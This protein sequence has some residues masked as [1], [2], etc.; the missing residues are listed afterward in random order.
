MSLRGAGGDEAISVPESKDCFALLAMTGYHT[1]PRIFV[2][3]HLVDSRPNPDHSGN[4]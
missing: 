2:T 4:D 3:D 1:H